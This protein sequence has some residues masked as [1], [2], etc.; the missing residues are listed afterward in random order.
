MNKYKFM[1]WLPLFLIYLGVFVI[2]I[3]N[4]Q[5]LIMGVLIGAGIFYLL[6]V[7]WIKFW[8]NKEINAKYKN[9]T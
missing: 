1:Q 3:Y 4:K 2:L 8:V 5:W 9:G 7:W 6:T